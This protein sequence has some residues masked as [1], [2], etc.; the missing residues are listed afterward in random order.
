MDIKKMEK[1]LKEASYDYYNKGESS[2][3]DKEFDE[4]QS[5][6]LKLTG[7]TYGNVPVGAKVDALKEIKHEYAAKSLDK[8]KDVDALIDKMLSFGAPD[9]LLMWKL[10][11]STVQATYEGGKLICAAT[12]GGGDI[13]SDITHNAPYISGLPTTIPYTGKLVVRGE[14][15]MSYS[16]FEKINAT[17]PIDEQYKNPRNLATATIQM[18]DPDAG[19]KIRPIN[20]NAFE[21][22]YVDDDAD[23]VFD[24]MLEG[25]LWLQDL[26][27]KVVQN[28]IASEATI[29]SFIQSW[30]EDAKDYNYP[31]DGL[32]I[33]LNNRTLAKTCLGETEHHPSQAMGYALKWEDEEV[34][35][36]L[37]DIIW[38]P[39]RT[40][41][42]NPVGVF[43][44]VELEGT[45]VTKATLHNLSYIMDKDVRVGDRIS[46]YKANKIIPKISKSLDTN[47]NRKNM[48]LLSAYNVPDECPCCSG[49]TKIVT[50]DSGTKTVMCTNPDCD[51]KIIGEIV[52]FAEKD[53]MDIKGLSEQK[54][55]DLW[56]NSSIRSVADLYYVDLASELSGLPGWNKKSIQNLID[57]IDSSKECDFVSFMHALSIPGIGKGQAKALKKAFENMD[58]EYKAYEEYKAK[59]PVS[60]A[61]DAE[62]D[63]F[64]FMIYLDSNNFDWLKIEDFGPTLKK[65]LSEYIYNSMMN[66]YSDV[67]RLIK[68]LHF[69]DKKPSNDNGCLTLKDLTFVITGKVFEFK[70]RDEVKVVI[71]EKGGKVT[72]SVTKNTNYLIN[73]DINSTS[74]KNKKAKEL[75]IPIIT[76]EEFLAMI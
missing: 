63:L 50:S 30:T 39:S 75:G 3:S 25:F 11:G 43:D 41:L 76:E 29:K 57:A 38:Q 22:V 45:T 19:V 20:F 55:M 54:I 42:L 32:V 40:G 72:G 62:F 24:S 13:G 66:Q 60:Y 53:C 73:N 4:L 48:A 47:D 67:Q 14:A 17:L 21:I 64:G 58:T 74:G 69:T 15:L 35:T 16:N 71:E 49:K 27:F 70:N 65:N 44:S 37:R 56:N 1:I 2:L 52:H 68:I 18:L 5:E 36:T 6:Y 34:E 61:T 59:V 8:T 46:V 10:D 51:A 31:V 26:G 12:R 28:S 9:L 33:A 23:W 7:Q